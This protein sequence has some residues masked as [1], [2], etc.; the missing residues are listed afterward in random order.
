MGPTEL[1]V[2]GLLAV[3][4]AFPIARALDGTP[5][6]ARKMT[7]TYELR[8]DCVGPTGRGPCIVDKRTQH[9][10]GVNPR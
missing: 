1:G 2:A 10:L 4:A 3:L 6:P 5:E 8:A 9:Q 7:D